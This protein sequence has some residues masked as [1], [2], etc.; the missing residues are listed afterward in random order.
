[1]RAPPD[2]NEDP[3]FHSDDSDEESPVRADGRG[4]PGGFPDRSQTATST[5]Y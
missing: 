2:E 5:Y 4:L 1:M 3:H